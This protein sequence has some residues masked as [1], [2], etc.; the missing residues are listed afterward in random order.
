MVDALFRRRPCASLLSSYFA[1][2]APR[3]AASAAPTAAAGAS[4]EKRFYATAQTAL[5]RGR[6][7]LKATR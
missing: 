5:I 7:A 2:D 1:E 4:N 3:V 6:A